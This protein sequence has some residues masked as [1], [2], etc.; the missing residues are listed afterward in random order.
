MCIYVNIFTVE[1]AAVDVTTYLFDESN[2]L[3]SIH[4]SGFPILLC[5]LAMFWCDH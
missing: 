2:A 5:A 3:N 1:C 4:I